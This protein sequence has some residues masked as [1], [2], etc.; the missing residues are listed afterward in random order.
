MI[1]HKLR[2]DFLK[3]LISEQR[4]LTIVEASLTKYSEAA[5]NG[6][7]ESITDVFV[8]VHLVV[9]SRAILCSAEGTET[10]EDHQINTTKEKFFCQLS[11]QTFIDC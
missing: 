5:N 6:D 3:K 8:V 2:R 11:F 4:T 1:K 10:R 9:V 7:E